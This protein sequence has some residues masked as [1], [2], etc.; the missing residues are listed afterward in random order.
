MRLFIQLLLNG[1]I[2]ASLF[3][4]IA[5]GFGLVWRSLGVFHVLYGGLYVICGY[6]FYALCLYARIP[7]WCSMISTLAAAALIG[8]LVEKCIYRPFYN[9]NAPSSA[10]LV[11]SLGAFVVA[12]NVV[13]MLFGDEIQ[14]VSQYVSLSIPLGPA[15]LTDIQLIEFASGIVVITAVWLLIRRSRTFKALWAMGDQP[16]LVPVLGLPLFWL[17][18]MVLMISTAIIAL[19]AS[20]ITL[21]SGIDPHVGMSY[22]L[23]AAVSVL[24][25]GRDSILGWVFSATTLALLQSLVVL[26]F[27]AQW[28]DLVTFS[29]LV[30]ILIMRPQGLLANRTRAEEAS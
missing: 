10:V 8:W 5:V 19:A 9:K 17:R 30:G 22:V 24:A 21:D 1:L 18:S 25:G 28:M 13:A 27:S 2:N 7:I 20:L 4:M 15:M 12:E 23:I 14:S 3:A 16:S 11:A 29:L 6:V 26:Q